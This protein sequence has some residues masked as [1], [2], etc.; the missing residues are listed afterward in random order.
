[1]RK[2]QIICLRIIAL[3]MMA[4][5]FSFIP[6]YLHEFFGDWQCEG[7]IP[8][9]FQPDTSNSYSYVLYKGCMYGGQHHL[10]TIHWGYR[11]WLFFT[12]GVILFIIQ[13]VDIINYRV[14]K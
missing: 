12:M 2:I 14:K 7:S 6:E 4:I 1:M 3:F 5:L 11:H 10:K 8:W 13:L 9:K